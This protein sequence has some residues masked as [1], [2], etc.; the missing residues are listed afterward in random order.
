VASPYHPEGRVLNVPGWRLFLSKGASALY[1]RIL[2]QKLHTYTSCFRVYRQS[3]VSGISLKHGGFLGVAEIVGIMDLTG[4]RVAEYPATLEVR[5][6]GRS[7]M[8]VVRTILG[9]IRLLS[10]LLRLRLFG[11]FPKVKQRAQTAEVVRKTSQL[12]GGAML[13]LTDLDLSMVIRL[14]VSAGLSVS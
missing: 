4:S 6:L 14:A 9:H 2:R 1:R 5:M 7:K 10:E 12:V 11:G 3:T 8:K 13:S